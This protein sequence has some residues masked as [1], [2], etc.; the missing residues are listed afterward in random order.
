LRNGTISVIQIDKLS[1]Y[2]FIYQSK[3]EESRMKEYGG[4]ML[5]DAEADVLVDL[6][7]IIGERIPKIPDEKMQKYLRD[8]ERNEKEI[9]K[10]YWLRSGGFYSADNH[11]VYL[12]VDVGHKRM[13]NMSSLLSHLKEL[14]IISEVVPEWLNEPHHIEKLGIWGITD[15]DSLNRIDFR[16][17]KSLKLLDLA[18]NG[19]TYIPESIW[20]V[21]NL[22]ELYLDHNNLTSMSEKVCLL[23]SL[24]RLYLSSN[25][26]ENIPDCIGN[27]PLLYDLSLVS[28]ELSE[29]PKSI[30]RTALKR[31]VICYTDF[32]RVPTIGRY[33]TDYYS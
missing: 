25:K 13:P 8:N 31:K 19:L 1:Y 28:N 17:M 23:Q 12:C 20:E 5:E 2:V 9:L 29:V 3:G 32:G 21:K 33:Y 30:K 7:H 16:N 11:V 10:G 6:E 15:Y 27:L 26:L 14:S 18:R 4:F 22:Q 24:R